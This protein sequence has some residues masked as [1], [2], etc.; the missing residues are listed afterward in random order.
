MDTFTNSTITGAHAIAVADVV[1]GA[2]NLSSLYTAAAV[3]FATMLLG[4]LKSGRK[5]MRTIMWFIDGLLGGAPHSVDLPGPPGMP[6][7]GNLLEV[8]LSVFFLI[9]PP[10]LDLLSNIFHS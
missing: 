10:L 8:S 6:I 5:L 2:R 7:V 9:L 3:F 4:S 1:N